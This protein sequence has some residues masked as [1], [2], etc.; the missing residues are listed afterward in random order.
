MEIGK[1]PEINVLSLGINSKAYNYNSASQL[2]GQSSFNHIVVA[3]A[4]KDP[5]LL[6]NVE[7]S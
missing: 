6:G 2:L 1:I 4:I 7:H 5:D 3:Q